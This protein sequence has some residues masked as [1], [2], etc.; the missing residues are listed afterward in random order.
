VSVPVPTT[1]WP[2]R[3]RFPNAPMEAAEVVRVLASLEAARVDTWIDGGWGVD[4]LLE[5][6]TREHD[7]LD[8]VL[9]VDD[10]P[11]FM[12]VAQSLGYKHVAGAPPRSFVLVDS[13]GRQIDVHP[14]S[15][16]EDRGGGVYIMDDG[17]EWIYPT[18]GLSGIGK[19]RA[20]PC[21]A[22]AR[23]CPRRLRTHGEGL[24]RTG[25]PP[26]PVRCRDTTVMSG[27]GGTSPGRSLCGQ[28]QDSAL[29]RTTATK[30]ANGFG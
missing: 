14:V 30:T 27:P 23:N 25:H 24:P 13:A 21:V 28:L 19:S 7:D 26:R 17:G 2:Y 18:A 3:D 8:L 9:S 10:V 6:Q 1:E 12:D 15:F 16:S 20:T 5:T 29:A 22:S 4:A 11:V